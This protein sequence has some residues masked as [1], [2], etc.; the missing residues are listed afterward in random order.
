[1][2]FSGREERI[3]IA[4]TLLFDI[5]FIS[6]SFLPFFYCVISHI[7]LHVCIFISKPPVLI[8]S[9]PKTNEAIKSRD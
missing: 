9:P 5:H 4:C 8:S 1:M 6:V 3:K 2:N 7:D